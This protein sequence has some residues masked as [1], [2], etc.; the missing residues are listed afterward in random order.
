MQRTWFWPAVHRSEF[1]HFRVIWIFITLQT[2]T[3]SVSSFPVPLF[4]WHAAGVHINR[5]E[6]ISERLPIVSHLLLYVYWDY[7]P[8]SALYIFMLRPYINTLIIQIH[9]SWSDLIWC[10]HDKNNQ[11]GNTYHE[12]LIQHVTHSLSDV[13]IYNGKCTCK[14]LQKKENISDSQNVIQ[15]HI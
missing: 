4:L 5:Q 12:E 1:Q 8:I 11:Y 6:T 10:V 3:I 7:L 9:H 14:V 13:F 2:C 15:W